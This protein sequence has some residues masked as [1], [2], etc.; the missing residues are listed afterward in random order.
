MARK[1]HP[2][3]AHTP[4]LFGDLDLPHAAP[5]PKP[6]RG[7]TRAKP[8]PR[9]AAPVLTKDEI[10]ARLPA[11]AE[12]AEVAVEGAV[13]G[14][15]TYLVEPR[16]RGRLVP[17]ARVRVP[18]GRRPAEGYY[19]GPRT[20]DALAEEGVDPA[21]L[22][23][24]L[25][26]IDPEAD[27]AEAARPLLT[28][29]LMDL[30]RWIAR[31]Y[32]A[33]LG[34]V[35]GAMLPAGVKRGAH[36]ARARLAALA[37]SREEVLKALPGIAK[38][39]PRQAGLLH[40]LLAQPSDAPLPAAQLLADAQAPESA[41]KALAKHGWIAL[42]EE[43]AVSIGDQYGGGPHDEPVRLTDAQ[44]AALAAI[45]GPLGK[46]AY[47][48]F[49]LQGVT[50]SGKTEVYLKVL[51]AA[52]A[53]GRQGIVLVP[54]IA[55]TPQT[56][57]RFESRLGRERVAVLH[58]HLSGGERAEA[59]RAA[60]EGKIDVVIGA[61]SALFA[62]LE[63]LG[64][65]V[66]DEEHEG[67]FKQ[68]S[69]PRY[70]AR[71]VA[72]ER[73]RAAGA[74]LVLG[75]ATPSLETCWAARQ[76][77]LTPLALPDRVLGRE[78]PPVRILDMREEN[79]DTK[80]FNYLS[81]SLTRALRETLDRREQA[82]LFLNRR[83][84]ATVIT[85]IRCGHTERCERC[86]ITLTSHKSRDVL[87]CHYCGFEKPVKN[88]CSACGAPGVKFWGLG[89][90]RVEQ[91]VRAAFP[92]ANVVRMDSDTM[93]QR[94]AYLEALSGFRSGSV[95]ILVGTQMIAKGLDF[96]NVT[97]VGIVLADTALHMPDFRSRERTFQL[98]EQVSGRAGRGE[99]GGRVIV[100]THLPQDPA[101]RAA[102][103]HDFDG[104]VEAELQVRK[105]FGY[106][107]FT[108]L[109]RVLL[110]GKDLGKLTAAGKQAA[111][112]LRAELRGT[113]AQV[114][115]PSPAPIAMLEGQHRQ[116]L[117]VKAPDGETLAALFGGPAGRALE[118][119][120]GAEATVDVD[121]LAML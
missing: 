90:E 102:A 16:L 113:G 11:G 118:K 28:P 32:A 48:G 65:I 94:A 80:R 57:Q 35:L 7:N 106:P 79:R 12:L 111:E 86:D 103:R 116:H 3:G 23:A 44:T 101:I 70:H 105:D 84:F 100:Q 77:G 108:R 72:E 56:A 25:D 66:I 74:V 4:S 121:P 97:L 69:A 95:D 15:F 64:C 47:H 91:E 29:P 9:P 51:A 20:H 92:E 34:A 14:T 58:S 13:R 83:G 49:L 120:K 60:R 30:A 117:L 107:P 104:F 71:A 75:S 43:A 46:K 33:S 53:A 52:R 112:T 98:I 31:Q 85:C 37:K 119:L 21:K 19:L 45:A 17:G 40:A 38:R 61:R 26:R 87:R 5:A 63:R 39:A 78:L 27:G 36:A 2:A 115:G 8:N 89:T 109:A 114:L 88:A 24:V 54:E 93:Q 50:G 82:I 42:S 99:K 96:P 10:L 1:R 22:K 18:F 81:R 76:R 41:L 67:A 55:L 59:W 73:A 110:R 6:A 62:P 68:D